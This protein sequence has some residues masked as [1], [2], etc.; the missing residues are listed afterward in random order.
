MYV[1][2]ATQKPPAT[3]KDAEGFYCGLIAVWLLVNN[4][5]Y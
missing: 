2:N 3:S 5:G 4:T 1:H